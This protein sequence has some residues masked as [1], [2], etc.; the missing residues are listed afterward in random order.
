M[1]TG[2]LM[3]KIQCQ[4]TMSVRIAPSEG[5]RATPMDVPITTSAIPM[6]SFALGRNFT[7]SMT[8]EAASMA[9]PTPWKARLASRT[10]NDGDSP[11]NRDPRV[12]I[13]M[14]VMSTFL[15]APRSLI[16]PKTR[17]SPAITR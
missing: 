13:A 4:D 2:T 16:L 11:Q 9:A 5:P 12:N 17:I 1:P 15:I 7:P 14:P 8:A 10:A 3:K 6:P